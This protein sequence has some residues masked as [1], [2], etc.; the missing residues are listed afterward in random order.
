MMQ[1]NLTAQVCTLYC[2]FYFVFVLPWF[3]FE[4]CYDHP[5]AVL[6]INQPVNDPLNQSI[7][8]N[9]SANQSISQPTNESTDLY[10]NQ[11]INQ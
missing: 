8:I 1:S 10:I 4:T 7:V 6:A 3:D 11:V 2:F 9:Q 5:A